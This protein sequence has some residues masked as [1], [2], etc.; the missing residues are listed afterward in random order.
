MNRQLKIKKYLLLTV[1]SSLLVV[2]SISPLM[3]TAI[4]FNSSQSVI[5]NEENNIAY[6]VFAG[7]YSIANH[8]IQT[9]YAADLRYVQEGVGIETMSLGNDSTKFV[10]N[11]ESSYYG[12]YYR[13]PYD[14]DDVIYVPTYFQG[15][16]KTGY[17]PHINFTVGIEKMGFL[18]LDIR[19]AFT[20]EAGHLYVFKLDLPSYKIFD[21]NA[22]STN[23]IYGVIYNNATKFF[24][25]SFSVEG[26]KRY[27]QPIYSN[28]GDELLMYFYVENEADVIIEPRELKTEIISPDVTISRTFYNAPDKIWNET[29]QDWQQ[30]RNKETVH[31]F[32]IELEPGAYNIKYTIFDDTIESK[33]RFFTD[34]IIYT[35]GYRGAYH[36]ILFEAN[37]YEQT[38]YY[39]FKK[40]RVYILIT[41]EPGVEFDYIMSIKSADIPMFTQGT[42][43]YQG[44][45]LTFLLNITSTQV[46][47]LNTSAAYDVSTTIYRFA[48]QISNKNYYLYY[49]IYNVASKSNKILLKPGLYFFI[50]DQITEH[51]MFITI[52]GIEPE[53][54]TGRKTIQ[55][56]QN[57]ETAD[58]YVL[59][60][61]NMTSDRLFDAF[62][63]SFSMEKNYTISI[64]YSLYAP[65]YY[66]PLIDSTNVGLGNQQQNGEF[67]AYGSNN[68]EEF[69][70]FSP[71]PSQVRYLLVSVTNVYNNTGYSYP[72]AGEKIT[73]TTVVSFD[74]IHTNENPTLFHNLHYE[75]V[76]VDTNSKGD[77]VYSSSFSSSDLAAI[78]ALKLEA[79]L[80]TW[81]DVDAL[82]VNGTMDQTYHILQNGDNMF[83][84]YLYGTLIW[85]KYYAKDL[86]S[87]SYIGSYD[88]SNISHVTWHTEF[89][90]QSK[91][92]VLFL[93]IDPLGR[94]GTVE[95]TFTAHNCSALR[96]LYLGNFAK[97]ETKS[98]L[99]LII[100]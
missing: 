84:G 45:M 73:N 63:F 78:Y 36:D 37:T 49:K 82:I 50:N 81:Y 69:I 62:N 98:D 57:K 7:D 11:L 17:A 48:P 12:P 51:D 86:F 24:V 20:L 87:M 43:H 74:L 76:S 93:L 44:K 15:L 89:G 80:L 99:G 28:P 65:A 25:S 88:N 85:N 66:Q 22:R 59:L 29:I 13:W 18:P 34:E 1:I 53:S 71:E 61:I 32:Y 38:V 54:F 35:E 2:S 68:T 94:N 26:T 70:I 16:N 6:G 39:A 90:T 10:A 47:F 4:Q 83:P 100:G 8:Y 19:T 91:Y 60:K 21:L 5:L 95:I 33:M 23:T 3:T 75:E 77:A 56:S 52:N 40:T 9:K 31:A 79:P 14:E 30:N 58:S 96:P 42:N 27:V 64:K 41:S 97:L 92:L 55:L 46:I 67:V 72:N